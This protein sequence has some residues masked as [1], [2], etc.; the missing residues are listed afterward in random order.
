MVDMAGDEGREV[1]RW[2]RLVD[3]G[4]AVVVE[5]ALG[6]VLEWKRKKER[7]G[8]GISYYKNRNRLNGMLL[9]ASKR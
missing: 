2:P 9:M 3:N 4:D 7:V 8:E 5:C 1:R 6:R